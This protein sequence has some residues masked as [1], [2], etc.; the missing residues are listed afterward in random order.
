M[1]EISLLDE[2]SAQAAAGQMGCVGEGGMLVYEAEQGNEMLGRCVFGTAGTQGRI[3]GISMCGDGL[4]PI[5]DGLLRSALSLMYGRGVTEVACG[6]GVEDVLLCRT[7]FARQG[8]GWKLL[9][10]ES[11]FAGCGSHT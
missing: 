3:Y 11:F 4:L 2:K 1:I 6:G 10:K 9:L 5:A 7:G 8:D